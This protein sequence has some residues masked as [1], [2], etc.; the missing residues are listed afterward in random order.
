DGIRVFHVT[1]VQTCALPIY[2]ATGVTVTDVLPASFTIGTI[3]PSQGTCNPLVGTTL[4]CSLGTIT[5]GGN[6]T[7]TIEATPTQT[8]VIANKIGRATCRESGTS[9]ASAAA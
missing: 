1:G 8:G 2:D 7:V 6:A 9:S 3:T 5:N 4:T